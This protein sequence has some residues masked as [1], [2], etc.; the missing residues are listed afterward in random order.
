VNRDCKNGNIHLCW[1]GIF[2]TNWLKN[3]NKRLTHLIEN[4]KKVL[5]KLVIE[6]FNISQI[7]SKNYAIWLISECARA[8]TPRKSWYL[9]HRTYWVTPEISLL[10]TSPRMEVPLDLGFFTK[11]FKKV[12]DHKSGCT[13]LLLLYQINIVIYYTFF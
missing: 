8:K 3:N 12:E 5:H 13:F 2:C 7:S 6:I 1:V 9:L 4:G 11:F 10:R